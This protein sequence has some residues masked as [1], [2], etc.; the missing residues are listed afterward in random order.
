LASSPR[1]Q[2]QRRWSP[3]R[4]AKYRS[5]N[6]LAEAFISLFKA[7]LIRNK[8]PWKSIDDLEIAVAEYIDWFNHRRLHGKIGLIP[9][10]EHEEQ[11]DRHHPVATTVVASVQSLH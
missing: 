9:P 3:D 11:H 7:E 2:H 10:V 8:G 5:I 6:A 4:V 1:T